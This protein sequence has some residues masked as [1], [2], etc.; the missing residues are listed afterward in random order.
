MKLKK[1]RGALFGRVTSAR[2]LFLDK[3]KGWVEE[4][5]KVII[6]ALEDG[7]HEVAAKAIQ[8]GLS[9]MPAEEGVTVLDADID[10]PKQVEA[11]SGPRIQIGIALGG[12]SP[13][14]AL[15][16]AP[17]IDAEVKETK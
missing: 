5:D 17:A 2:E 16:E 7:N 12:L 15:P 10:I 13:M 3:A 4:Y 9:H 1:P 8:W 14:K 11:G 6:A